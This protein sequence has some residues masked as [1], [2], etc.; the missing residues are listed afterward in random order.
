MTKKPA[1]GKGKKGDKAHEALHHIPVDN[2]KQVM[3]THH[4][5]RT[6]EPT[7]YEHHFSEAEINEKAKSLSHVILEQNQLEEQKKSVMSDYKAKIDKKQEQ[8]NE[9]SNYIRSGFEMRHA[10]CEVIKDFEAGKKT[11]I[12]D[13]KTVK[14]EKMTT[15]DYTLFEGN[16]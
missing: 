6:K 1:T 9:I 10:T 15:A 14:E 5:K 8:I 12:L 11:Y 16:E 3:T 13:G 4:L 2:D 7:T